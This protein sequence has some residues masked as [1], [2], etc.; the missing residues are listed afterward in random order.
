MTAPTTSTEKPSVI[1][2][3][4]NEAARVEAA[5]R[6]LRSQSVDVE[7]VLVDSGSTDGTVGLAKPFCDEIVEIPQ[8]QF[9]FGRSLN[10]G[11]RRASGTVVFALSAHCVA[12][13]P[14]WVSRHLRHYGDPRVGGVFGAG[15]SAGSTQLTG[16]Y[17][18][19]VADVELDPHWGFSNHASSWRRSVWEQIP[20]DESMRSCEDKQWMWRVLLASYAVI[21]DPSVVVGSK[22]RRQAGARALWR[23]EVAEHEALAR[24]LDYPVPSARETL[25]TWWSFFPHG[26]ERP[27]WQRRLSPWR[28]IEIIGGYVGERLGAARRDVTTV[29]LQAQ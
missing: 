7:I 12:P 25:A 11:A 1:V 19:R 4:K 17:E 26:S 24:A 28:N 8:E 15:M 27:L 21:A 29:R 3:T 9:T 20:F 5:L 14:E 2:R 23:R 22:H 18:V 10:I 13:D 6:S 16:A